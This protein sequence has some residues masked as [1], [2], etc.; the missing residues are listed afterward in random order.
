MTFCW[1]LCLSFSMSVLPFHSCLAVLSPIYGLLGWSNLVV[2]AILESNQVGLKHEEWKKW[3]VWRS[4][5]LIS[6]RHHSLAHHWVLKHKNWIRLVPGQHWALE[7]SAEQ[8]ILHWL[9]VTI[10]VQGSGAA[11]PECYSE[12][13]HRGAAA[14]LGSGESWEGRKEERQ[15]N[16]NKTRRGRE[17]DEGTRKKKTK[18]R[19]RGERMKGRNSNK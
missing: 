7:A 2:F 17:E 16:K 14:I 6:A 11:D 10:L 1:C 9:L 12:I 15:K 13:V 19:E 4:C 18:E 5:C 3:Q 8:E